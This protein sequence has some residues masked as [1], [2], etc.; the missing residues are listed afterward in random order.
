[1]PQHPGQGMHCFLAET[2]ACYT[3]AGAGVAEG[4]HINQYIRTFGGLIASGTFTGTVLCVL[5]T[6]NLEAFQIVRGCVNRAVGG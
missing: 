5:Q 4:I 1:M 2:N 3:A 6:V